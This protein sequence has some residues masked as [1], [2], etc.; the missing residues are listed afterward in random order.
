MAGT[1][2]LL[3][4]TGIAAAQQ[5]QVLMPGKTIPKYVDP[6]PL[7]EFEFI[8]ATSGEL[9][10][11][12]AGLE[13]MD[14]ETFAV[15]A[16]EFRSQILPP[17]N[18]AKNWPN[19]KNATCGADTASSTYGYRTGSSTGI[20]GGIHTTYLGPV[21]IA[22]T[23]VAVNPTYG[24]KLPTLADPAAVVQA[25]LP[26]DKTLDWADPLGTTGPVGCLPDANGNYTKPGHT[27]NSRVR[28]L[29]R[30]PFK[31]HLKFDMELLHWQKTAKLDYAVTTHWYAMD[32]AVGNGDLTPEKPF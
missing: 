16:E 3:F 26:I 31:S 29:D 9:T 22:E 1:A 27:T 17:P 6:L 18:P 24:N 11:V 5:V 25:N 32:G 15:D 7:L 14:T 23:G 20:V 30:I 8:N 21:V 12:L 28:S 19:P 2:L 13:P 10:G 4:G